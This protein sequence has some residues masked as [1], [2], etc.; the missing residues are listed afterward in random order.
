[1]PRRRGRGHLPTTLCRHSSSSTRKRMHRSEPARARCQPRRSMT[2]SYCYCSLLP[3]CARWRDLHPR[4]R[5]SRCSVAFRRPSSSAVFPALL[6]SSA[7]SQRQRRPWRRCRG[8]RPHL[9]HR[10]LILPLIPRSPHRPPPACLRHPTQSRGRCRCLAALTSRR[11]LPPALAYRHLRRRRSHPHLAFPHRHQHLP[12]ED[13]SA[14]R[15]HL[16]PALA[17][18]TRYFRLPSPPHQQEQRAFAPPVE[19]PVVK[20][21]PLVLVGSSQRPFSRGPPSPSA[22]PRSGRG[23]RPPRPA[24]PCPR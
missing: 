19:L 14:Q 7:N 13:S 8:C 20:V 5:C 4:G 6:A 2:T 21:P 15:L 11:L 9:L 16:P 1:M 22:A 3:R 24:R 10:W 18:E 17:H 23:A 12:P